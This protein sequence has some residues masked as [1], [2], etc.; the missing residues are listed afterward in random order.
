MKDC[1]SASVMRSQ[2]NRLPSGASP[3]AWLLLFTQFVFQSNHSL[4]QLLSIFGGQIVSGHGLRNLIFQ[5]LFQK[6]V[7]D[8][9]AT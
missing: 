5:E 3:A 8:V 2:A 9:V 1:T 7:V 6:Q 4:A